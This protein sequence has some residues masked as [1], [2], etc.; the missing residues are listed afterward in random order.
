VR[1][2]LNHVIG[3]FEAIAAGAGGEVL[4]GTSTDY[5]ADDHVAAYEAATARALEALSA[6]GA[7]EKTFPMPWGESPGR[8]VLGMTLAD[9]AV[10]GWDLAR[11]TGQDYAVDDDVAE[12][13][14]GMTTGMMEPRGKFPR[15]TSFG[16]PVE[17]P[18]GASIQ[19]KMVAYL[20]RRP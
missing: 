3:T 11:A 15:G 16:P 1:D 4:D 5:T 8:T 18:A 10:H 2:L 14:Y 19:D 9:T 13:V 12:A 6:P 17:V 7:L 20:G